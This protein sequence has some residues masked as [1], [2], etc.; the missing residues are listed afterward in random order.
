VHDLKLCWSELFYEIGIRTMDA[1]QERI[2]TSVA[3]TD[4]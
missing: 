3:G 4:P 2:L 1:V